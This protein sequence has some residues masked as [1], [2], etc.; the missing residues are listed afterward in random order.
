MPTKTPECL[1]VY[2]QPSS[3]K[4]VCLIDTSRL[5]NICVLTGLVNCFLSLHELL[6]CNRTVGAGN[7]CYLAK[8]SRIYC[9]SC[10]SAVLAHFL[11]WT[12]LK[13]RTCLTNDISAIVCPWLD[14]G[15]PPQCRRVVWCHWGEIELFSATLAGVGTV[16]SARKKSL[17][18][19]CH[20][21]ELNPSQ[22]ENRQ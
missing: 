9:L 4:M 13:T 18:I 14:F 20:G 8:S 12:G 19:L 6:G 17:E 16:W 2:A 22:V 1:Q 10:D 3:P 15:L 5:Q 21:R 7:Q 11:S